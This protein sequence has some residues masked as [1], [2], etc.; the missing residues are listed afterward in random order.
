MGRR[1]ADARPTSHAAARVVH[2]LLRSARRRRALLWKTV[3]PMITRLV[4]RPEHSEDDGAIC[5][6]VGPVGYRVVVSDRDRPLFNLHADAEA[7]TSQPMLKVFVRSVTREADG[8][9]LYGFLD[10]D[11][12]RLFDHVVGVDGCG[13][14]MAMKLLSV[15]PA[16]VLLEWMAKGMRER[17]LSVS[18]VG[19]KTAEK[20]IES[21]AGMP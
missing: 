18:G 10:V 9:T 20:L 17:L 16:K 13:P 7:F 12:R 8:T 2:I 3:L 21:R 1:G 5:L 19:K 11:D 15:Q 6:M 4:G 14:G